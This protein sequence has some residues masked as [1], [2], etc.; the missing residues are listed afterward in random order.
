MPYKAL[1]SVVLLFFMN[2]SWGQVVINEY[3]ASNLRS[4]PDNYGKYEDWI[5]LYNPGAQTLDISGWYLSDKESKPKKWKIPAGTVIQA[6]GFIIF[7]TSGRDESGDGHFHT[8][9]KFT[10]TDGDEFVVLANK[11]GTIIE[12]YPLTLTRLT[13]SV[14]KKTDGDT[15]L[16]VCTEPTPGYSNNNSPKYK[17]YTPKPMINGTAGFYKDSVKVSVQEIA[18]YMIRYTLD[19]SMP[20]SDSPL[21]QGNLKIK[22]TSILKVRCFSSDPAILP[23]FIDFKTIFINEP[24]STLPIFSV[25]GGEDV[26]Q[27]AEGQRELNPIASIEV[28]SPAGILTSTSFGELDSHGQDSWVNPQRSIDWISRDE[29]GYNSGM[30]QK[31][32]NYSDREDYQRIIFRASGDDNYPA[33]EDEAHE[34]STHIRDEFVHTL[35]QKGGMNLDVRAV[36]RAILYLNGNYWGVY[37][38]REKP[39][40]H[41]YTDFRYKQDKYDLQFLKTWGSSWAEYGGI[42]AMKDWATLRDYI[43]T[44][45]VSNSVI[46]KN[47]T[48]QLD[49]VSLMD[50]M[51]ANLSVVSSDWMNYN[52]GWW[53]GLNPEGSHKKWAYIMWDNDATFNYYINYSGVPDRSPNAKACDLNGI[54]DY[55]DIFFP[56][57][58]TQVINPKD[59]IF[60]EGEWYY[61]GPDT[62]DVYPD[63]GRHEKI[64]LRL[65]EEN[66]EFRNLYFARYADMINKAFSCEN[67]LTKLDSMVNIIR[68]E[69]PRHINK[70]G[71]SMTEWEDNVTKLRDFVSERCTKIDDGLAECYDLTG[72]FEVTIMTDPPSS[73]TIRLNTQT[74]TSL[75]WKG[76]YFGNMTNELEI[77]PSGNKKFQFWKSKSGKS[78][79]T[80]SGENRTKVTLIARDTIIAV[81]EG[82]LAVNDDSAL[83]LNLSPNPAN[84]IIN[85][86]LS[87]SY[88]DNLVYEIYNAGGKLIKKGTKENVRSYFN[89]DISDLLAGSYLVRCKTGE[90][91]YGNKLIIIR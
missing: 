51:I 80:N 9:F 24:T 35:I 60:W 88:I 40:D 72:P 14:C 65:L 71:R 66:Q 31:L 33:I 54:S 10:Q 57:D 30:I 74:H 59:S 19:G 48:D 46:Y 7:W 69:M 8:N 67:M 28:F 75:P 76:S 85:I 91:I 42:D 61:W 56:Q 23:G 22:N 89:L 13:H 26:I 4:Y 58:T 6:K 45:D 44:Q 55:M 34:G 78:T 17:G 82:A 68:P 25:S 21:F 79:F 87:E 84:D 41:D 39:D 70:W 37:A 52:T 86:S 49:V 11:S 20:N 16:M 50:Y 77:S 62:F 5:E 3:S 64:F 73:G 43:L 83:P 12:K 36:E 29:M 2:L 32:F 81:F 15:Q 53:R 63:L 90:K 18:G 38:I 1:F 47:I 27:L